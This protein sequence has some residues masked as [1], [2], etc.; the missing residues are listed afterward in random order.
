[1][2]VFWG[3]FFILGA[4]LIY[5]NIVNAQSSQRNDHSNQ[6][7]VEDEGIYDDDSF[8]E[9]QEYEEEQ[10]EEDYEYPQSDFY[11]DTTY[12]TDSYEDN[13]TMY[14]DDT[15]RSFFSDEERY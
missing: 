8:Q 9:Y 7:I 6:Y 2:L 3:L 1:M 15:Y 4:A 10:E 5:I 11:E 14:D 12:E 13:S